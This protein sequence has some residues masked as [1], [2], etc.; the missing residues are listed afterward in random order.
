[1]MNRWIILSYCLL[2]FNCVKA[3][4]Q[5]QLEEGLLS[6]SDVYEAKLN[7]S[8]NSSHFSFGPYSITGWNE[9]WVRTRQNALN[10]RSGH[11]EHRERTSRTQFS[12]VF[13]GGP[14][15]IFIQAFPQDRRLQEGG[16]RFTTGGRNDT[17][18]TSDAFTAYLS[19]QRDPTAWTLFLLET[20]N[21]WMN[22]PL[23]GYI[24]NQKDTITIT[25][26]D[27]WDNGKKSIYPV[28]GVQLWWEGRAVAGVQLTSMVKPRIWIA[29]NL[30]EDRKHLLAA[31]AE[32]ILVWQQE[33]REE[34]NLRN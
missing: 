4:K 2:L 33:K 6:R 22:Q 13:L 31:F 7:T 5:I 19:P 28:M 1:M 34:N 25:E 9:A 17:I 12:F 30:P 26:V 29:S 23:R 32:L 16:L 3:Q 27:R 10:L 18:A 21:T 14:D 20:V 24:T 15:S 11:T 8:R